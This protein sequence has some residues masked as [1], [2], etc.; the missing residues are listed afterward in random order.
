MAL[1]SDRLRMLGLGI[2]HDTPP[3]PLQPVLPDGVHLRWMSPREVAFPWFGYY[4]FRRLSSRAQAKPAC[5]ALEGHAGSIGT[6]W[7]TPLGRVSS[8]HSIDLIADLAPAGLKIDLRPLRKLRLDLPEAH[9]GWRATMNFSWFD[10][11]AQRTCI[12]LANLGNGVLE[13]QTVID[14]VTLRAAGKTRAA[15]L[16]E[17][18]ALGLDG[19]LEIELPEPASRIEMQLATDTGGRIEASNK[20]EIVSVATPQKVNKGAAQPVVLEGKQPI[21][22]VRINV[23]G[24]WFLLEFCYFASAPA[25]IA[26]RAL[27]GDVIVAQTVTTQA[28]SGVSAVELIADRIGAIEIDG[29]P[30][31]LSSLCIYRIEDTA[32]QGWEPV[33]RCKLP[34]ALPAEGSSGY[35][36]AGA[37]GSFSD[38]QALAFG[39]ITYG[40]PPVWTAARFSELHDE[41]IAVV[42]GGPAG[43]AMA[44][45]SRSLAGIDLAAVPDS[46]QPTMAAQHPLDTLLLASIDPSVAQILGLYWCD[47]TVDPGQFYDYLVVADP[48]GRCKGSAPAAL[49]IIAAEGFA[50]LDGAIVF[51]KSAST[52]P[53]LAA[54]ADVRA[55]ALP[56]AV[57]RAD[58]GSP[59]DAQNAGGLRWTADANA[60]LFH[61]W[62]HAYGT[63][64]PS[65]EAPSASFDIQTLDRPLLRGRPRSALPSDLPPLPEFPPFPLDY[66]DSAVPDG[67]YGYRVSA[68]DLFGRHSGLSGSAAWQ[69]WQPVPEPRPWYYI[70][71]GS[72]AVV[73]G[74]SI[75]LL[76]KVPPPPPPLVEAW[77]LDPLDPLVIRDAAYESWRAGH[78]AALGLRV[79]WPWPDSHARQAPDTREFRLYFNAGSTPP[80]AAEQPVSWASRISVVDITAVT[81][82]RIEDGATTRVYETFLEVPTGE[83]AVDDAHAILYAQIGVTAADDKTHT[84]DAPKW[85]ATPF[86]GRTGNESR[87]SA[88]ATVFRVKRDL[89][90]PPQPVADSE[91]V[92]AS[93]ADYRNRSYYTYR[94]RVRPHHKLHVF[95]ALDH[96]VFQ[97]D[98]ANRP[99][100][101]LASGD[102]AFPDAA[103][104]PRW[105]AAKRAAVA[106][107]IGALNAF[108]H[109]ESGTAQAFAAYRA[110]SN[111]AL[112][113]LAGQALVNSAFTQ[114]TSEPLDPAAPAN[115]DRLGPDTPSAY[116][117]ST[118]LCAYIDSV[119][120]RGTNRYFYRSAYLDDAQNRGPLG[121]AD[122]P[123][124]VPDVVPPPA[125]AITRAMGG[126]REITLGWSSSRESDAAAYRVYRA[127]TALEARD[128]RAMT[129]V[130]N[131]PIAGD[132][133]LRPTEVTWSDAPVQAKEYRYRITCIDASN[134]ESSPTPIISATAYRAVPPDA[135]EWQSAAR[136]AAGSTTVRLQWTTTEPS[137]VLVQRR[138]AGSSIWAVRAPSL[139]PGTLSFDDADAAAGTSFEYRLTARD[140]TGRMSEPGETRLVG[141]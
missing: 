10:T 107:E 87:V 3:L 82:T 121:V 124:N 117:P 141:A 140:Q 29:G 32:G 96:S 83:L 108:A 36:C 76:D 45:R 23:P 2:L 39:R 68:I 27:D 37:P 20:G 128:I 47:A 130:H 122:P 88:P 9:P 6:P 134:N 56:G 123:V 126:D 106:A 1:Q 73:Q 49:A 69:Q 103:A 18:P 17:T 58:D 91:A 4:L 52:A 112:R 24:S 72:D 133:V 120:G 101:P 28:S 114:L 90:P 19:L 40:P 86:G 75:A 78:A 54:P 85:A 38:A 26:V 59:D 89:P 15:T 48:D 41:V 136:L 61:V 129:L 119:E 116:T 64:A 16:Q 139:P 55:Y 118:A 81:A 70:G 79:R 67:W 135:P 12:S 66:I 93:R 111:D 44:G 74:F 7:D 100:A 8:D 11:R 138:S 21:T 92:F 80:G 137:E 125:P 110:L 131:E 57:R 60:I 84:A 99:R 53:P 115:A 50:S 13:P 14:G 22:N 65:S 46:R 77:V 102:P 51:H 33:P 97:T 42:N 105:N 104:E 30:A 62:R 35:P 132:L 109:D 25:A 95:R 94:W 63:A 34:I 98:W 113:V 43:G 127:E 5:V 31:A 71:P